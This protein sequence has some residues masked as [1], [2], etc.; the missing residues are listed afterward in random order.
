LTDERGYH[1]PFLEYMITTSCD[2]AC[3][4]CDRFIDYKHPWTE[5][6]ADIETNMDAWSKRLDPDHITIIGGEPLIHPKI[7]DILK[8]SRTKFDH[9]TVEVYTN[10]FLLTKRPK[11][12]NVLLDIAPAKISLTH[13][14]KDQNARKLIEENIDKI[15]FK[16][17]PWHQV[18]PDRYHCRDVEIEITDPTDNGW[19]DYRKLENGVLKPH[20][21]GDPEKSYYHCGVNIY[22]IIYNNRLYKCPPIS[23][24]ETHAKKYGLMNDEDWKPYLEYKGVGIDASDE[25]LFGLISNIYK[26]HKICG[27]CP[28]NPKMYDQPDAVIKHRMIS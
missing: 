4:G 12:M 2:L 21:D 14:T 19:M 13:H 28:A 7:Y 8:I 5:S 24:L 9:A 6:L 25:E 1:I 10:G 3:P 23:M 26:H 18:A 11:I 17:L 16:D 27:M 20:N 22:P 15:L